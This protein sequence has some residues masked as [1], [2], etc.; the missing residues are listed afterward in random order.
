MDD[1]DESKGGPI[2]CRDR[3]IKCKFEFSRHGDGCMALLVH[4]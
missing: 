1:D 4:V 2:F 3:W